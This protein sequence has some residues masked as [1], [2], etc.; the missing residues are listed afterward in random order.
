MVGAMRTAAMWP[1]VV[2]VTELPNGIRAD[3]SDGATVTMTLDG[4]S[5]TCCA[6]PMCRHASE[7]LGR[8]ERRKWEL[9]EANSHHWGPM[10]YESI[11]IDP[12]IFIRPGAM[13]YFPLLP[14]RW[15]WPG[16]LDLMI[17]EVDGGYLATFRDGG[18]LW[19]GE[20][21][22]SGNTLCLKCHTRRCEHYA[23]AMAEIEAYAAAQA[24]GGGNGGR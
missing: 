23:R 3:L 8:Y 22:P 20:R 10:K 7:A 13:D 14:A 19:I 9:A 18:H 12:R 2:N 11:G 4:A 1:R 16:D 24:V 15:D 5:C 21:H 6:R 17:F